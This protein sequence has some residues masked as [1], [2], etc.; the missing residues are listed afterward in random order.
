MTQSFSDTQL[1]IVVLVLGFLTW[2]LR[3]S[4]MAMLGDRDLP[5][6]LL[7]HLRYTAVA[8]MPGLVAP[9][10]LFPETI[11]GTQDPMRILAAATALIIGA[12]TRNVVAGFFAGIAVFYS[13][14]YLV[15]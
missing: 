4:F 2:A 3:F 1:W 8:I 7:R 12:W 11:G 15:G 13:T 5:E 10:V 9:W 14:I 6:W